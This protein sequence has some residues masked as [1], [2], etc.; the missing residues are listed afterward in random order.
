MGRLID[1]YPCRDDSIN[2]NNRTKY[3]IILPDGAADEPL[4]E[5]GGRTCLEVATKP[6]IDWIASHGQ[7]GTAVTVPQG[8]TPGSD[9]ATLSVLGYDPAVYYCGRAP[10]EAA[11]QNIKTAPDDLIFR[12]NLTTI[13]N[14]VMVDFS[15]GHISQTEADVLV[16]DLNRQ[17]SND[18]IQFYPGVMYRHL[19]TLK[20]APA[21][22]VTCTPPHDIIDQPVAHHL[23]KGI[24]APLVIDLMRRSQ[25]LLAEHPVNQQRRNRNERPA[26]SIWLWGQGH[27]PTLPTF[28][29][30]FGIRGATIAAVDLIRGI[31]T[32]IGWSY[33]PVAGATGY[34]NTDFKGKGK[35]AV[36]ALDDYDLVT[37]HIEAPDEA[38]HNGD[39]Q[40][41]IRALE[42]IDEHIVGPILEK[43]RRLDHWKILV[44]PDHPTPVAKRTHTSTPPPYCFAG[45]SVA[46]NAGVSFT[47][48]NAENRGR[49]IANGYELMNLFING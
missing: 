8:F 11:A 6:H 24:D 29:S 35:R 5:L 37:V 40:S 27:T 41:K 38:G 9:V 26:T 28:E 4:A 18:R 39:A 14:D 7:I 42:Q 10:L 13:L 23:P 22:D 15:A 30:R 31:S 45:S 44:M 43:L 1:P 3:A 16:R 32:L 20:N 36:Q 48:I 25:S 49:H 46:L 17:L 2:M 33:L 47:E 12:C 34:L 19:M 21:F